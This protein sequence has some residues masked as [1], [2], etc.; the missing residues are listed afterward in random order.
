MSK[1]ILMS[2]KPKWAATIISISEENG[3]KFDYNDF[4]FDY[5]ERKAKELCH[6]N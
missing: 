4:D 3:V 6:K 1:A 2:I 5:W